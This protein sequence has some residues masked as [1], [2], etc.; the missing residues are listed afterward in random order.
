MN[1]EFQIMLA[2]TV[3]ICITAGVVVGYVAGRNHEKIKNK[4][5]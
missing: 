2:A 5:P 3:I 1:I 4:Q